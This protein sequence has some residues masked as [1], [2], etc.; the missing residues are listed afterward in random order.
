MTSPLK[1]YN[2]TELQM[3]TATQ[4]TNP[5]S[6]LSLL[7][8][9]I[10]H[11]P[12]L[13]LLAV[14]IC[15]VHV[16]GFIWLLQPSDAPQQAKVLKIVQVIL[17][18]KPEPKPEPKIEK[19]KPI[20]KKIPP[21]KQAGKPPVKEKTPVVKKQPVVH[22]PVTQPKVVVHKA[23]QQ[24]R[25][26]RILASKPTAVNVP[27]TIASP[28]KQWS[29]PAAIRSP[30]MAT[31]PAAVS[32]PAQKIGNDGDSNVNSGVAELSG[33]KPSYPMMAKSRHIEG[34]CTVAFTITASGTISNA[35][36]AGCSPPG[37]FE[38]VSLAAI[39]R[40]RFKPRIANGKPVSQNASK[41]FR[42]D[43]R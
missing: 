12:L 16:I 27:T 40:F 43:L 37:A 5:Q 32:R 38:S 1:L 31:R 2:K 28:T 30:I 18:P 39:Q 35:H 33:V 11:R 29:P 14:A 20:P 41:T 3:T 34:K 10:S 25:P 4:N 9:E 22:K 17:P 8:R 23:V 26:Q 15:I 19:P 6:V 42:F 13:G 7:S 36:A 21:K 24:P